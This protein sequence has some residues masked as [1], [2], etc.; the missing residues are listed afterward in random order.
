[1]EKAKFTQA[2]TYLFESKMKSCSEITVQTWYDL[3]KDFPEEKVISALISLA[4]ESDQFI[5]VGMVIEKIN[6]PDVGKAW[7]KVYSVACGGCRSW[8]KLSDTEIATVSAIG[9]IGLIQNSTE[10]GLP[11]L[12]RDFKNA[13]P[14]MVKR[15]I[16]YNTDEERLKDLNMIPETYLFIKKSREAKEIGEGRQEKPDALKQMLGKI[17]KGME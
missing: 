9:G 17:G 8:Q 15:G 10:E 4:R 5:N 16:R 3:L 12:C 7:E 11:F 2:L 14:A 13:Y 1:M 6:P